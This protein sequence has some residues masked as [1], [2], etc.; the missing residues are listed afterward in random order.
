MGLL[1]LFY[2]ADHI[3]GILAVDGITINI[4]KVN[5]FGGLQARAYAARANKI[6]TQLAIKVYAANFKIAA[7]VG[8]GAF[9]FTINSFQ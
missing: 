2:Q 9:L 3:I 7:R 8:K 5:L 1:R 4:I 6:I